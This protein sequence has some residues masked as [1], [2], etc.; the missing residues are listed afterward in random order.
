MARKNAL[1]G[2]VKIR[3][4]AEACSAIC[5]MLITPKTD[6]RPNSECTIQR[7]GK[8]PI[9]KSTK[10]VTRAQFL[11][12]PVF[13]MRK[14]TIA[15]V[16]PTWKTMDAAEARV[17]RYD[18]STGSLINST[19]KL[20]QSRAVT[21]LISGGFMGITP[22]YSSRTKLDLEACCWWE[23]FSR[24]NRVEHD[25]PVHLVCVSA[26]FRGCRAWCPRFAPRFW[27]LT[28]A[29]ENPRR[30]SAGLLS[31]VSRFPLRLD[32]YDPNLPKPIMSV[33]APLPI[34]EV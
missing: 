20:A 8:S 15:K 19:T 23:T 32:V 3:N 7:N 25:G 12:W 14:A 29:K 13:Q 16:R 11:P 6:E 24:P 2:S 9:A 17:L 1:P 27:A 26:L 34:L 10:S 31:L 28:W 22:L 33:A 18:Q 30:S 5:A 4:R 21:R